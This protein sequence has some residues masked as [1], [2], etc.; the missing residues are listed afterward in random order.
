M[1]KIVVLDAH[2]TDCDGKYDWSRLQNL[3]AQHQSECVIYPTTTAEQVV[4]QAEGADMLVVSG[5][6]PI[7]SQIIER[8]SPKLRYLMV[9]AT[10]TDRVDVA[11]AQS[12]GI[13]VANIPDYGTQSVAEQTI[14]TIMKLLRH[15]M[16][17]VNGSLVNAQQYRAAQEVTQRTPPREL[18]KK[19]LGIVGLG[20]I[21]TAVAE[22][23]QAFGME[24]L[25]HT[26]TPKPI[27]GLNITYCGLDELLE[28]A[29]V[30]SLHCDL[31]EETYGIIN[32]RNLGLMKPD[33]FLI[34]TSRGDV[35]DE[36]AL[37][38]AILT[39]KIAG[40]ALDVMADE[41]SIERGPLGNLRNVQI[42]SHMASMTDY[43]RER[44]FDT[45]TSNLCSFLGGKPEHVLPAQKKTNPPIRIVAGSLLDNS[46][47]ISQP[48]IPYSFNRAFPVVLEAN[49]AC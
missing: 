17:E 9:A 7:T 11:A 19:T 48:L 32:R 18:Y 31:N 22:R 6:T 34:N 42:T 24:I 43:A 15:G 36:G 16:D 35:I 39:K 45:V 46:P 28:R 37:L 41:M 2:V 29:D 38:D 10:G 4:S 8:L 30:V 47:A 49:A 20:R 1:Q 14:F 25:V 13:V 5:F 40:A 3:A 23:A 33:A 12:R 26:R 44:L 21:G 27:D